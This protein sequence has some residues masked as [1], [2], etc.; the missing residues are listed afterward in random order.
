MTFAL[1]KSR[2]Y[3]PQ[4]SDLLGVFLLVDRKRKIWYFTMVNN[5]EGELS[6]Q[7]PF[8]ECV[9]GENVQVGAGLS[10]RS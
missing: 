7:I 8:R 6:A 4:K 5:E 10:S 2:E 1:L 3:A 9:V